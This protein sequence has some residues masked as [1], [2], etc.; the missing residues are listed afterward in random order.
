MSSLSHNRIKL[1]L[2]VI[3]RVSIKSLIRNR[4]IKKIFF[5]FEKHIFVF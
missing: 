3:N 4:I 1:S 5:L 2:S